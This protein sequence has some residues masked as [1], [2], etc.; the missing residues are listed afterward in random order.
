MDHPEAQAD[1]M[2]AAWNEA[3]K[4]FTMSASTGKHTRLPKIVFHHVETMAAAFPGATATKKRFQDCFVY[5]I[6]RDGIDFEAWDRP[7]DAFG[8][9]SEVIL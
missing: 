4:R 9:E 6:R 1:T 8:T 3:T 5:M 2:A 7:E